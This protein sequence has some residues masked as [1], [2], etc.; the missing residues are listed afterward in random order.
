MKVHP[1]NTLRIGLVSIILFIGSLIILGQGCIA[2]QAPARYN[3][4]T[5]EKFI[6]KEVDSVFVPQ[7][8]LHYDNIPEEK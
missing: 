7:D 5:L 6:N 2:T 8:T 1:E 3:C 4:E